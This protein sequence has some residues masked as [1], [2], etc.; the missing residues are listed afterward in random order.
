M[1]TKIK[2]Y[3]HLFKDINTLGKVFDDIL[4]VHKKDNLYEVI[5]YYYIP[6]P[7]PNIPCEEIDG[8]YYNFLKWM[9]SDIKRFV[10]QG[11]YLD[12]TRTMLSTENEEHRKIIKD[13]TLDFCM[14][15]HVVID[16][17]FID[18]RHPHVAEKQ[19]QTYKEKVN[20]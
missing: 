20:D 18:N 15:N 8:K 9:P 11:D 19:L 16:S 1:Q 14:K 13:L 10:R 3:K 12:E 6:S 2:T 7:T 17:F 4:Q 5:V